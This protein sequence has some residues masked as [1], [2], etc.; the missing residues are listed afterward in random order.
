[1]HG[2]TIKIL[3]DEGTPSGIRHAEVVNWT[4]QAVLCPR[5]RVAAL[6]YWTVETQRPGVY[7]LLG[8]DDESGRD[9]V[10]V[11]EAEDVR[12]RLADH[13]KK[14]PFWTSTIVVTSKDENLTK[15]HVKYLE[16]RLHQRLVAAKR[17]KLENTNNPT[18]PQLPRSDRHAME[19]FIENID[20]LV[21]ALGHRFLDVLEPVAPKQ[22][23]AQESAANQ[24]VM[25]TNG[26]RATGALVDDGFVVFAGS[27]AAK[28]ASSKLSPY[29]IAQRNQLIE[30]S[31]LVHDGGL[32]RFAS[33]YVF[34]S[35]SS[36]ATAIAGT[37]RN[38]RRDWHLP[39]GRTLGE[40]EDAL[41]ESSLQAVD[42]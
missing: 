9:A 7:F 40:V 12:A 35:P 19:E 24:S 17:S 39:D 42:D 15:A 27:T 31:T 23:S 3:L 36:A 38:G 5:T 10:Y 33:S 30:E 26:A 32:L 11:G 6:S 21:S 18:M 28:S 29:Q 20:I 1:M 4:G 25:E 16:A 37:T 2:R 41:E 14:K 13:V 8:V 34:R 22:A